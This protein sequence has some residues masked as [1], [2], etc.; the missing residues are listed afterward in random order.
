MTEK[1]DSSPG[2]LTQRILDYVYH[3]NYQPLKPKGIHAALGLATDDYPLVRKTIKRMVVDGHLAYAGNHLVLTPDKI[4]G[5][6]KLIRGTFR[7]AAAGFGL[8]GKTYTTVRKALAAA[9][10]R[11]GEEDLIYVGGSIFVVAEVV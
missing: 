3:P 7:Q 9:K 11:A 1:P 10:R 6:P 8:K 4:A 2:S 5:D